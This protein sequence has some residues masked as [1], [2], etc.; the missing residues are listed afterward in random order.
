MSFAVRPANLSDIDWLL[1]QLASFSEM[2]GTRLSLFGASEEYKRAA[3]SAVIEKHV[4][5]IAESEVD[6]PVGFIC[7]TL[8]PHFFNPK[9]AV[10][11]ELFWWVDPVHRSGRA[12]MML[13]KEFISQGKQLADWV[14]FS[15]L[16]GS[17]VDGKTL[18]KYGF[19]FREQSFILE[20]ELS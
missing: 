6:G 13:L 14:M 18:E 1:G 19:K 3:L 5:L 20:T 11:Q 7:G 15:L 10:L 4:L 2:F 8:T 17:P 16:A 9:I 12:G